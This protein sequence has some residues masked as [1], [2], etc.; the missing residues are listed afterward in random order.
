MTFVTDLPDNHM[1]LIQAVPTG[2]DPA[3]MTA[4]A[5]YVAPQCLVSRRGFVQGGF[6]GGFL[7]HVMGMAYYHATKQ[8]AI[9]LN[10]DMAMSLLRPV[11]VGPLTG[12]GWVV[13][14]G[15]RVVYLAGE[16][17]DM[18]GNLL[19]TATSTAI[20]TPVPATVRA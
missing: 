3:T 15:K 14:M 7:D 18:E 16:L 13:R 4:T 12:K 6:V 1:D 20:P 9:G 10:L 2:F 17:H 8:E 11:E 5:S 19:A